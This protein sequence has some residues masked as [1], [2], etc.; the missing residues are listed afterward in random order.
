M[1]VWDKAEKG[2]GWGAG[3]GMTEQVFEICSII[4]RGTISM[5]GCLDLQK[6]A[7]GAGNERE[8]RSRGS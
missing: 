8:K 1:S 6:Y 2:W 4:S 7:H 3:A 5:A